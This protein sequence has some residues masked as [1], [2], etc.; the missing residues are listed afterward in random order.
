MKRTRRLFRATALKRKRAHS[1]RKREPECRGGATGA[2]R[3][4][5]TVL[6]KS[7]PLSDG[8]TS[9]CAAS[10]TTPSVFLPKSSISPTGPLPEARGRAEIRVRMVLSPIHNHDLWTIAGEYGV[11]PALP[12]IGGT[13]ALGVVDK[14]GEGVTTPALGRRVTGS[15]V[16][17]TWAEYFLARA[18]A[19]VPVPDAISDEVACQLA[20]CRCRR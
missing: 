19:V 16:A 11:K 6:V 9:K 4:S 3:R 13:E 15:G 5:K 1:G 2:R 7:H 12:A 20:P 10:S 8:G 18:A 14:L 17:D